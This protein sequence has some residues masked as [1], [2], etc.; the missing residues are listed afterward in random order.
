MLSRR[1]QHPEHLISAS[2][3][4]HRSLTLFLSLI[5]MMVLRLLRIP[6]QHK[7][8]TLVAGLSGSVTRGFFLFLFIPTIV[9]PTHCKVRACEHPATNSVEPS[10]RSTLLSTSCPPRLVFCR[11][12]TAETRQRRLLRASSA[13]FVAGC[14]QDRTILFVTCQHTG[15]A[16]P[17]LCISL[18][19][20]FFHQ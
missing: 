4:A 1:D 3:T 8:L 5:E 6:R 15:S 12:K 16:F 11:D 13:L 9:N 18:S 20:C 14:P 19:I 7:P 17:L 10:A 2:F